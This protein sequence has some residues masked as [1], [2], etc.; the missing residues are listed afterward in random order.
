[1]DGADARTPTPEARHG[2]GESEI[3]EAHCP[4][5]PTPSP[6]KRRPLLGYASGSPGLLG[7]RTPDHNPPPE[8][9]LMLTRERPLLASLGCRW[10]WLPSLARRALYPSHPPLPSR[11]GFRGL[12]AA[13]LSGKPAASHRQQSGAVA[14]AIGRR[15]D[16]GSSPAHGGVPDEGQLLHHLRPS[17][18]RP[19]G[20]RLIRNGDPLPETIKTPAYKQGRGRGRGRGR[21]KVGSGRGSGWGKAAQ[22]NIYKLILS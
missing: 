12:W 17:P 11:G 20:R 4:A 13:R 14:W 8:E 1:V 10:F 2:L 15:L 18:P 22:E 5:S 3:A 6:Q 7:R 9:G 21:G 16:P 19:P